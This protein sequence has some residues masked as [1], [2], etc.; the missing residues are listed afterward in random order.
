MT[1]TTGRDVAG[2]PLGYFI[3]GRAPSYRTAAIAR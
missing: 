3:V 2:K 1:W